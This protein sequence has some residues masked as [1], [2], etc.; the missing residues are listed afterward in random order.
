MRSDAGNV[1]QIGT[2]HLYRSITIAK[3]LIKKFKIEKKK[4]YFYH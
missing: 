2:G 1:Q 3:L 4:N